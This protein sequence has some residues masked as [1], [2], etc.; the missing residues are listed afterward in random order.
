MTTHIDGAQHSSVQSSQGFDP[1]LPH[2]SIH[3]FMNEEIDS[4]E[5]EPYFDQLKRGPCDRIRCFLIDKT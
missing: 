5:R 4:C 1:L 3:H 2:Y